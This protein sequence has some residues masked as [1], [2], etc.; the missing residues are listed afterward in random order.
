MIDDG[1]VSSAGKLTEA[2]SIGTMPCRVVW[3]SCN[4]GTI[5]SLTHT[6]PRHR[7]RQGRSNVDVDRENRS[8]N[9]CRELAEAPM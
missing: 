7:G 3:G 8:H 6:L 5:P 4:T 9:V 1:N 2:E